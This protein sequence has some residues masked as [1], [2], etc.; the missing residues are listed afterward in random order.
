[1]RKKI[2]SLVFLLSFGLCAFAQAP[3]AP[4]ANAGANSGPVGG[5]APVGSG[6]IVLLGLSAYYGTRKT[7]QIMHQQDN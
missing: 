7:I 5:N 3:P 6:L 2:L 4:P 1:M